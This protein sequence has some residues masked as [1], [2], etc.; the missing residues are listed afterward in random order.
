MRFFMTGTLAN[1]DNQCRF[2]AKLRVMASG[3]NFKP[4][5]QATDDFCFNDYNNKNESK[6]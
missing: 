6:N 5:L 4:E 3:R 1:H 2:N